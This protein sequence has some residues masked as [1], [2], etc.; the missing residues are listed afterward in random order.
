MI[1]ITGA[2]G[3]IAS[4]L[5]QKLNDLGQD[6]LVLVDDFSVVS[7]LE[8]HRLVRCTQ[9]IH[10]DDFIEWFKKNG[11]QVSFVYHLGAR[12][13]TT[14]KDQSILDYLNLNYSKS[15]FQLCTSF[16]IPLVYA[17][18]A[19]TYGDGSLGYKDD[20]AI[21]SQLQPLNLYGKSKNDFDCWVL[22]Q[23]QT[24]PFWY[25]LKFFN[26]FG[27]HE[28]HKGRMAS[29]VYHAYQQIKEKGSVSLFQSHHPDYKDG[30]QLRDFVY[31]KEI[32]NIC[33][34]LSQK[35]PLSGIYNAGSGKAH[36]FN[37]LAYAVFDYLKLFNSIEYIPMPL[38]LRGKYQYFTQADM[39]KI[40]AIGYEVKYTSFSN[41]VADYLSQIV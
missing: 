31:V 10:R 27:P 30:E 34:F 8:N 16:E 37:E 17:S 39:F 41:A 18:S 6:N 19:A 11:K 33:L 13:D 1:V 40:Q 20:H 24:P 22:Q 38:D 3:F 29:V 36:S 23:Q 21:V 26:V 12:T 4:N 2:A 15:I 35:L 25:G 14:E 7:K 5:V 28:Q 32:V 9:K